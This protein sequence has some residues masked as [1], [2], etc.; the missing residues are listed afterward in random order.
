MEQA[1]GAGGITDGRVGTPTTCTTSR[2]PDYIAAFYSVVNWDEV[3]RRFDAAKALIRPAW[4]Q[5][6]PNQPQDKPPD[7]GHRFPDAPPTTFRRVFK[8]FC[9]DA[10]DKMPS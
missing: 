9:P 8:A 4:R 10:T 3:A 2:R 7:P 5:A 1:A 6:S